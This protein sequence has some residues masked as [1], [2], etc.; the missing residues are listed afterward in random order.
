VQYS[1][2]FIQSWEQ[3]SY[4]VTSNEQFVAVTVSRT[5]TICPCNGSDVTDIIS[6][7]SVTVSNDAHLF[8]YYINP[9]RFRNVC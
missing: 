4:F 3:N 2:I 7:A 1:P 5:D 6:F 9:A 8:E